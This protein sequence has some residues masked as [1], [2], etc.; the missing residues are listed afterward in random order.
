M[1]KMVLI[2]ARFVR[3]GK[4]TMDVILKDHFDKL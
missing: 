3:F 4:M 2:S 1:F